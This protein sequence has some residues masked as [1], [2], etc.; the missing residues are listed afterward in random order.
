MAEREREEE[1]IEGLSDPTQRKRGGYSAFE[2]RLT[3]IFLVNMHIV[4]NP[5][6][7]DI[8]SSKPFS[9]AE[10]QFDQIVKWAS[11]AVVGVKHRNPRVGLISQL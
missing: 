8:R 9:R 7:R 5:R 11:I 6:S 3:L 1:K 10:N 4:Q 2:S